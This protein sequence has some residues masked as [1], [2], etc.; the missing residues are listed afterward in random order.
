MGK[1]RSESPGS[2]G[3]GTDTAIY[4]VG[5]ISTQAVAA[6][7]I[8]IYARVLGPED[9]GRLEL[10]TAMVA[11]VVSGFAD[12][13]GTA[14]LR[15]FHERPEGER[16]TYVGVSLALTLGVT[17]AIAMVAFVLIGSGLVVDDA[18]RSLYLAAVLSIPVASGAR[19]LAN[20]SRIR[21]RARPYLVA[22]LV[23]SL[24]AGTFGVVALLAFDQGAV[25]FH[26]GVVA[27]ALAGAAVSLRLESAYVGWSVD[28]PTT[29]DLSA[30]AWP[31]VPAGLAAW[32]LMLVDRFLLGWLDTLDELGQY[33]LAA[34]VSGLLM[35]GVFAVQSALTPYVFERYAA[36]PAAE[37][38]LRRILLVPLLMLFGVAAALTAAFAQEVVPF[39]AGDAYEPAAVLIPA[40]SL[41]VVFFASIPVTQIVLLIEG[42]TGRIALLS[43][44]AALV[45]IAAGLAL[46]P[47]LGAQGAA[48]ATAF[49]FGAQAVATY[50]VGQSVSRV[51]HRWRASL[52]T[53]VLLL[54]FGATGLVSADDALL[55]GV[56]KAAFAVPLCW[57]VARQALPPLRRLR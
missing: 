14:L 29:R 41:S 8:V 23:R 12:S 39:V 40:L 35:L 56:L 4:G 22:T 43:G 25:S 34:R 42:Q 46:I 7:T 53:F 54:G 21:R 2:R 9:L 32:S 18:S 13:I 6:I 30:Y 24:F 37:P 15:R 17:G 19:A 49:G 52:P 5:S 51:H 55:S 27:G 48:C 38:E 28:R 45:N 11:L 26:V 31:L 10:T 44:G 3:L 57:W 36:D 20:L 33:A 50:A 16:R 47:W 1:S